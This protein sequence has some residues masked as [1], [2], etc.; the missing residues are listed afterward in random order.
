MLECSD[1]PAKAIF[2]LVEDCGL[3]NQTQLKI[4]KLDDLKDDDNRFHGAFKMK[5]FRRT[6]LMIGQCIR[7]GHNIT[8]MTLEKVNDIVEN[9]S[10]NENASLNGEAVPQVVQVPYR[11]A[12]SGSESAVSTQYGVAKVCGQ[13]QSHRVVLLSTHTTLLLFWYPTV[14]SQDDWSIP[15][16]GGS[17]L[18]DMALVPIGSNDEPRLAPEAVVPDQ[19][20]CEPS[21]WQTSKPS[22]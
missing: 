13:L 19:F 3:S 11:E 16:A 14:H 6:L 18:G 12:P 9:T 21:V 2:W 4:L 15:I 17:I 10:H 1:D 5:F 20:L 22:W 7:L 8:A